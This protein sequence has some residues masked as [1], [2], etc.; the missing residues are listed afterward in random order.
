[1]SRFIYLFILQKI[2][3]TTDGKD[4]LLKIAQ[5][6]SKTYL[7][8]SLPTLTLPTFVSQV[9]LAR[10]VIRLGHGVGGMTDLVELYPRMKFVFLNK[11]SV[12]DSQSVF[13]EVANAAIGVVNDFVDDYICMGKIGVFKNK[14]RV[15]R[16]SVL[17]DRLWYT[18]IYLDVHDNHNAIKLNQTQLYQN[19]ALLALLNDKE[20]SDLLEKIKKCEKKLFMLNVGR[21]KLLVDWIFCSYDVFLMEDR[22]FPIQIQVVSGLIASLLGTYKIYNKYV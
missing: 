15:K 5:Y 11:T 8:T 16:M 21:M 7:L 14:E 18:T 4:K 20:K 19:Q 17:S 12:E 13:L 10:K 1:M 6:L 9:S 3:S 22:G 2:L